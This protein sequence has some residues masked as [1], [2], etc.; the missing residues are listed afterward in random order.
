M[1]KT[2]L[3]ISALIT[4]LIFSA[5]FVVASG[6]FKD[7]VAQAQ[8]FNERTLEVCAAN[9]NGVRWTNSYGT[10][11]NLAISVTGRWTG[12]GANPDLPPGHSAAGSPRP[13][14]KPHLLVAPTLRNGALIAVR[15]N[16]KKE[17]IGVGQGSFV[18]RRNESVEFI[19]NDYGFRDNEGCLDVTLSNSNASVRTPPEG[20]GDWWRVSCR[21]SYNGRH[22]TINVRSCMA[23]DGASGLVCNSVRQ[24]Q[25]SRLGIS[26]GVQCSVNGSRLLE[27]AH[28]NTRAGNFEY[29]N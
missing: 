28:C 22:E 5:M 12:G 20:G 1:K 2:R 24:D 26:R 21:C 19:M 4:V 16:G 3:R 27:N 8:S 23:H 9:S 11:L 6:L 13:A 14:G 17:Y 18:I 15:S 7:Q 25:N 10:D 29:L